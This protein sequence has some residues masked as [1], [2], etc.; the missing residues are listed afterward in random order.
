MMSCWR[1]INDVD[2]TGRERRP[3]RAT[4]GA[5]NADRSAS[6]AVVVNRSLRSRARSSR[7]NR[8]SSRG[9]RNDRYESVPSA[10]EIGDHGRQPRFSIRCRRLDVQQPRERMGESKLVLQT[11]DVH[12]RPD[13][14]VALPVQADED[15]GLRQVGP[16]Q[17]LR[18]VWTSAE[19]EHHRREPKSR[20]RASDSGTLF[21]ELGQR[22]A[23]EHAQPL[24]RC[25]DL[26]PSF[27]APSSCIRPHHR[28]LRARRPTAPRALPCDIGSS[29][30]IAGAIRQI[31]PDRA[32]R[33]A[34][35]G[36]GRHRV[37]R[38]QRSRRYCAPRQSRRSGVSRA[39]RS[40]RR[41][42]CSCEL[43]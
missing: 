21:G 25:P 33:A 18:W 22:G 14:S 3:R 16:I 2:V 36:R 8:P 9:L 11:R 15:V 28:L 26:S 29:V 19:L 35:T 6:R 17:L 10:L 24:V 42:P 13:P 41:Y 31:Q 39:R 20:D 40:T 27:R 23:H 4:F 5:G 1:P 12:A 34:Q 7:T 37:V 43:G 38:C 30:P 32:T